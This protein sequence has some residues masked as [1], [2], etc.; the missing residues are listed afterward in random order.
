M[1]YQT[2]VEGAEQKP[3]SFVCF[4][5]WGGGRV[6]WGR[7][8]WGGVIFFV[9]ILLPSSSSS[10]EKKETKKPPLSLPHNL[11]HPSTPLPLPQN[12]QIPANSPSSPSRYSAKTKELPPPPKKNSPN[13]NGD[14]EAW[15]SDADERVCA[16]A[17]IYAVRCQS[18][19]VV[20]TIERG[21]FPSD[22]R[23]PCQFASCDE[24][25]YLNECQ[26]IYLPHD[27]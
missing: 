20:H 13:G 19:R 17:R 22:I 2:A 3:V 21:G 23:E 8:G 12:P 18:S 27:G 24:S 11:I 5:F 14:R 10:L 4:V 7:G 6:V 26:S 16:P 1:G 25:E 9:F 15:T